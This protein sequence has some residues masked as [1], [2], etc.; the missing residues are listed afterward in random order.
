[1]EKLNL[2]LPISPKNI[3]LIL[4]AFVIFLVLANLFGQYYKDAFTG[5][6]IVLK[7]IRK[8]NLDLE[9][10]NVPTWYQS[11]TLVLSSFLLALI[12]L[13]RREAKDADFRY[14]GVLAAIFLYLS[15]DEAVSIH[16]QLTMPLRTTFQLEGIFYLSWVIPAAVFLVIF[17]LAFLKF[18]LRL[19]SQTRNLMIKAGSIYVLGAVGVEMV[20]GEYLHL[21]NDLPTRINDFRYV[22]ITTL[23]EFL[24][25]FGIIIF[26]YGLLTHLFEQ[27]E[28]VTAEEKSVVKKPIKK[29]KESISTS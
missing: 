20:G 12:T 4:F 18:L 11:S 28:A 8:F 27:E 24:E 25:M 29:L 23:E 13:V 9:R 16:E 1:M 19:S 10:N 2:K 17:F 14:W 26:I 7:I 21:T 15:L 5:N 3:A 22:L 6:E